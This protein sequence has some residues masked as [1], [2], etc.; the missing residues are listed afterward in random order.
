MDNPKISHTTQQLVNIFQGKVDNL[1]LPVKLITTGKRMKNDAMRT[2]VRIYK[3]NTGFSNEKI[4]DVV[5]ALDEAI[6]KEHLTDDLMDYI[7]DNPDKIAK[8]LDKKDVE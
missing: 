8:L 1:D 4:L 5:L 3:E 2:F 7:S 6:E